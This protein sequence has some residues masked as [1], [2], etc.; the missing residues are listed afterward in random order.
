M[1]FSKGSRVRGHRVRLA[2]RSF[3]RSR[4]QALERAAQQARDVHLG[5]TDPRGYL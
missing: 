5:D 3:P 4:A 1:G 2:V